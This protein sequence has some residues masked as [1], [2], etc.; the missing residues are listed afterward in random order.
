MV[1]VSVLPCGCCVCGDVVGEVVGTTDGIDDG[2]SVVLSV[3]T[4]PAPVVG[5]CVVGFMLDGNVVVG[6]VDV[7]GTDDVGIMDELGDSVGTTDL[8]GCNVSLLLGISVG[9]DVGDVG[10][11]LGLIDGIVVG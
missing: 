11:I 7:V 5:T 3:G 4:T 8:V 6:K 10:T 9:L 1:L 2:V